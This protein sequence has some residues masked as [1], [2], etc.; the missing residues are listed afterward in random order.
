MS[1]LMTVNHEHELAGS[2][3]RVEWQGVT[4]GD[5]VTARLVTGQGPDV[6]FPADA[7]SGIRRQPY[8]QDAWLLD[9]AALPPGWRQLDLVVR[10]GAAQQVALALEVRAPGGGAEAFHHPGLVTVSDAPMVALRI[11]PGAAGWSVVAH[12]SVF[13]DDNH[14]PVPP[15][16]VPEPLREPAGLALRENV[17]RRGEPVTALVD[18]SA[19]MRPQLTAGTVASVL[20]ALQAVAGAAGQQGVSVVAVSDTVHGRRTLELADDPEEFLRRWTSEVGLRTGHRGTA[21]QW[22]AESDPSGLVV[23]IADHE[24]TGMPRTRA[25]SCRV[26]LTAPTPG[27]SVTGR[28]GTVT[29]S[30]P[31]PGAVAVVQA[32]GH[33]S[34]A[35]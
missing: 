31:R 35:V 21:E 9:L 2:Q 26:V 8:A 24:T 7:V 1:V 5:E 30:E 23:S 32:L 29:V 12:D 4:A 14:D 3:C 11:S 20:S 18:L 25:R 34:P 15:P 10:G 13:A 19:S 16:S 6:V 17:V 28:D 22:I 27:R 33:A